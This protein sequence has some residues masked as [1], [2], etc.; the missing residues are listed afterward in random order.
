M[1]FHYGGMSFYLLKAF[2]MSLHLVKRV[3]N[4]LL[5]ASYVYT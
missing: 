2:F 4:V 5:F 3:S 1:S